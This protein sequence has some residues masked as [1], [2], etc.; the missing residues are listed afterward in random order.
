MTAGPP[1]VPTLEPRIGRPHVVIL[2][3]GA[4]RAAL[5]QGDGRGRPLPLLTD[6]V[7]VLSL[8]PLLTRHG[9]SAEA[10]DFEPLYSSLVEGGQYTDLLAELDGRVRDYFSSL[11][12]PASPTLYDHLVLSLRPKDVIATFNWDPPPLAVP[13]A[14]RATTG[15]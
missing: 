9:L 13:H 3:A 1:S 12:L 11:E 2:G 5:P 15:S 10:Q 6:L 8:R 7:D 4:S 14:D